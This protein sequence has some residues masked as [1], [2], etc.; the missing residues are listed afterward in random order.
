MSTSKEVETNCYPTDLTDEQWRR[1]EP[2]LP[3]A[4]PGGRPRKVDVRR[5]V[6]AI[7]YLERSGCAWRMLPHDFPSWQTVYTYFRNWKRDGIWDQLHDSLHRALR[8]L[9]GH[10]EAPSAGI[11]D[12]QS[13]KIAGNTEE[14]GY[15]AGKKV[16]GQKRQ[17]LVDTLGLIIAIVVH[18][19][20]I[21]DYDGALPMLNQVSGQRPR[22]KMIWADSIY[23]HI[24]DW[25][26]YHCG[27]LVEIVTRSSNT[28]G[29]KVQ[30]HR[31]V[32]ERTFA[33][34][35][36]YRRH[37]KDYE[38][39]TANSVA[40]IKIAMTHLMLQRITRRQLHW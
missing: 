28:I 31:W 5:I 13:M 30:P 7:L 6:N 33:W 2:C 22:L 16:S 23:R 9:S 29:F 11:L 19:A 26:R 17:L 40:H 24:V 10:Y 20:G 1:L 12:S 35:D 3:P 21:Q 37:S 14:K 39:L 36:R 27:W 8:L 25:V 34:I 18:S 15:D 38:T 32:V 4:K